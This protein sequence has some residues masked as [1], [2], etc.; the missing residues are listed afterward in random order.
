MHRTPG[1]RPPHSEGWPEE[2]GLSTANG[3]NNGVAKVGS[4]VSLAEPTRQDG[5]DGTVYASLAYSRTALLPVQNTQV[6]RL[7]LED[8]K[9]GRST[10]IR[11][12]FAPGLKTGAS[13]PEAVR[14]FL[15]RL[16]IQCEVMGVRMDF[17]PEVPI[18]IPAHP[19]GVEC[20]TGNDVPEEQDRAVSEDRPGHN[21]LADIQA[22][23]SGW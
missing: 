5:T 18:T 10:C 9:T 8:H 17:L 20:P 16:C 2:D 1:N 7:F 23:F 3:P 22:A 15:S 21:L 19:S 14:D 11:S 12:F 4:E 6:L 13:T